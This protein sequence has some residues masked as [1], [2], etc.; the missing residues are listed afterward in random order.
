MGALCTSAIYWPNL[1]VPGDYEDRD[2]GG[3]TIGMGKPEYSEK[4]CP[5]SIFPTKIPLD[6]TRARTR[7]AAVVSQRLTA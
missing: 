6:Q 7:V 1:H 2:F 5:S 3:I 4:T